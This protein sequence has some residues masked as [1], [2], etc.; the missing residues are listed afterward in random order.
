MRRRLNLETGKFGMPT[1]H[2]RTYVECIIQ[3]VF[4]LV[5]FKVVRLFESTKGVRVDWGEMIREDSLEAVHQCLMRQ[6]QLKETWKNNKWGWRKPRRVRVLE[7]KEGKIFNRAK[8]S[9]LCIKKKKWSLMT[10]GFSNVGV[11]V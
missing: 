10:I 5:V 9:L 6:N 7:G 8:M 3:N 4:M 2:P 1:R 11:Y